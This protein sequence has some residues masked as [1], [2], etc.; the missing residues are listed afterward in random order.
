MARVWLGCCKEAL[1][2]LKEFGDLGVVMEAIRQ[3]TDDR[4]VVEWTDIL[5]IEHSP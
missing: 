2:Y 4:N 3:I 1:E 5:T